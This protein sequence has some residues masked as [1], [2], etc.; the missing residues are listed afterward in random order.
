[1]SNKG[2]SMDDYKQIQAERYAKYRKAQEEKELK[3]KQE[4]EELERQEKE[5]QRLE[6]EAKLLKEMQLREEFDEFMIK[7]DSLTIETQTAQNI[8]E[9]DTC[10]TSFISLLEAHMQYIENEN[11]KQDVTTKIIEMINNISMNQNS[12]FDI[13][14][15]DEQ[16]EASQ[17]IINGVK[18]ML[19]LVNLDESGI[20]IDIMDT[21]GDEELA[22][23]MQEE[24]DKEIEHSDSMDD[25]TH[26]IKIHRHVKPFRRPM[27]MPRI[28][29]F[30]NNNVANMFQKMMSDFNE[31]KLDLNTNTFSGTG[32]KL[33]DNPVS[34]QIHEEEEMFDVTDSEINEV[35]K[36]DQEKQQSVPYYAGFE[37]ITDPELLQL[38]HY[39][40]EL[41][42]E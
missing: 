38:M 40:N 26:H 7:L 22:K 23:K 9:I 10:V 12:K 42:D 6:D 32:Y 31:G 18:M 41:M 1:M 13:T 14:K 28:H 20:N 29:G 19:S 25:L 24:H 17:R 2:A 5:K 33:V 4:K 16:H 36:S 37:E 15:K 11:T 27:K 39:Q 35:L 3:L 30:G 21:M 34:V 8:I